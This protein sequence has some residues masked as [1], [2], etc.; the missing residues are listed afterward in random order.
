VAANDS[1]PIGPDPQRLAAV[2]AAGERPYVTLKAAATLDG[3]IATRSG[4]SRWISGEDARR[5][6]MRLR[7]GHDAVLVGRGTAQA[8]D[9]RLTVRGLEGPA[10]QARP[11]RVVLDSRARI[12]PAALLLAADGARRIVVVGSAAP[13]RRLREL[14][15]RGAEVLRC[16]TPRPEPA[17]YLPLLRGAGLRALLVEGGAQVHADLIAH[18]AA[19]ELF[20][21]IAGRVIGDPAAPAWCGPLGLERLAQA[22][23]VRLEAP[24]ALGADVLLHGWFDTVPPAQRGDP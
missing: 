7:A 11:A 21:Y 22:P 3:K 24:L 23:R 19:N 12:D 18:G 20:L 13:Q 4:E 8:D 14:A 17:A 5:H 16:A 6:A 1:A 2:L 9:P 10:A 15:E